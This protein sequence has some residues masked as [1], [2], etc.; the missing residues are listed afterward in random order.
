VEQENRRD[1]NRVR[2][3]ILAPMPG[4][5]LDRAGNLG[6]VRRLFEVFAARD[7]DALLEL[8]DP[9]IEFFGPT[10]TILREGRCYRGHEGMR[11]YMHDVEGL[12][13]ELVLDPRVFRE[14]GNHVVAIGRVRGRAHDGLEVDTPAA[15]VWRVESGLVTWGCAYG[16]P[17]QMPR[18]LQEGAQGPDFE[19]TR[20]R[21]PRDQA[22]PAEE[23][24]GT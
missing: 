1:W 3:G 15:W 9:Q 4:E 23:P 10:A 18:S 12:W 13:Q 2:V 14:I 6:L 20:L 22:K 19:A 17:E 5:G 16:D 11:R 7:L 21:A 24:L 8:V